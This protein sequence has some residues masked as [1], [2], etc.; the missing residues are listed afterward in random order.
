MIKVLVCGGRDFTDAHLLDNILFAFNA[1]F[2]ISEL[3][4]GAQRGADLLADDWARVSGVKRV[5]FVAD[6]D[7]YGNRAGNIRNQ[8]MLQESK[9]DM[10]IAFPG[11][12][13]T[14]DMIS[15]AL[16]AG[17]PVHC[18]RPDGRV[19]LVTP[20]TEETEA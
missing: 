7:R 3:V 2:V 1:K 17:V 9:P 11:N 5:P 20:K 10:V 14:Q 19:V 6:W 15:R 18:V 4:H 16:E 8:K 13:G 12:T